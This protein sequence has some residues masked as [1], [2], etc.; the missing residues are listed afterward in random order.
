METWQDQGVV[1][2]PK[3]QKLETNGSSEASGKVP[4]MTPHG[5]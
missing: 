5:P 2:P 4:R 3:R 1:Q